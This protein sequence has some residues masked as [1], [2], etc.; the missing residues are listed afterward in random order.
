[1]LIFL[2][3]ARRPE[4]YR[5]GSGTESARGPVSISVNIVEERA[6][7]PA[8]EDL[9]AITDGRILPAPEMGSSGAALSATHTDGY[10]FT[11]RG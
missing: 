8:V 4:M 9:R 5:D 3:K 1:L 7:A 2:L 6:G 11:E 10:A